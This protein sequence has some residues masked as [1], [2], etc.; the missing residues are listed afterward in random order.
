MTRSTNPWA[1]ICDA[2]SSISVVASASA[3]FSDSACSR[4]ARRSAYLPEPL[5]EIFDML[6][7]GET[8]HIVFFINWIAWQQTAAGHGA[9]W[10]RGTS[11]IWYYRRAIGRL[12]GQFYIVVKPMRGRISRRRRRMCSSTAS[13]SATSPKNVA[14]NTHGAWKSSTLLCAGPGFCRQSPEW[15]RAAH[16]RLCGYRKGVEAKISRAG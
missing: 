12:L 2:L 13:P 7:R 5:V 4:F 14:P 15:P 9:R 16:L 11:A 6:V 3:R 8:R 10:V 1:S